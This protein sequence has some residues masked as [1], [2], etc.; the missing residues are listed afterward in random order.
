MTFIAAAVLTML[1][2]HNGSPGD[3]FSTYTNALPGQ[4]R[5]AIVARGFFCPA[6]FSVDSSEYCTQS[7]LTGPFS[8]VAVTLSHGVVRKT[9]FVVRGG[10][11]RIGDLPAHWGRPTVHVYGRSVK[12]DWSDIG[13]TAFG[14]SANGEFSYFLQVSRL[15]FS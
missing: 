6:Y 13:V 2:Q 10:A 8:H 14:C 3:P 11:L 15:E 7:P 9:Y 1:A 12:L 4:T 5:S